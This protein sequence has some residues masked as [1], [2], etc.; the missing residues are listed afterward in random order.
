[1]ENH[2]NKLNKLN[3]IQ[4]FKQISTAYHQSTKNR[5]KTHRT[6]KSI[7]T[8]LNKNDLNTEIING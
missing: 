7:K 5:V 1:M 6:Q 2:A 8:E 4:L 3:Q